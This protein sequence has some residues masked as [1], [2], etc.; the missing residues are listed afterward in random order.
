MSEILAVDTSKKGTDVQHC[1]EIRTANV[2]YFVGQDAKANAA[3]NSSGVGS[4]WAKEWETSIRKALMPVTM[5]PA[6]VTLAPPVNRSMHS[7]PE[8]DK[9]SDQDKDISHAYQIFPDEVLG[10]GQFGIVYGGVHRATGHVVAIKVV[11]ES[12][13]SCVTTSTHQ[14]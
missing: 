5:G 3:T 10:S 9:T 13:R 14:R 7:E 4:D 2:D 1:F 6:G 12:L 8:S 11:F